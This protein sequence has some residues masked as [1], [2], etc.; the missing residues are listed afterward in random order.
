MKFLKS[1]IPLFLIKAQGISVSKKLS[2]YGWPIIIKKRGGKITLGENVRIISNFYANLIGLYQRTIII[3][4]PGSKII[5]GNNV[6]ISGATIF[7][8]SEI[9]IGNNTL[10]GANTKILDNDFHPI[11]PEERLKSSNFPIP[12]GKITIGNNVFIGCNCIILK[13]TSIGDNVVIG[14]GSVVKGTVPSNVIVAGN[15]AVIVK[16]FSKDT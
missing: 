2:L 8:R 15:P 3:S 6:G 12:I 1:K 16:H 10:I 4:Y 13:N 7:S 11:H 5:I 9:T 14:A